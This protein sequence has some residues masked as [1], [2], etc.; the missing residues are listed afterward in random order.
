MVQTLFCSSLQNP[1]TR[2]ASTT[3]AINFSLNTLKCHLRNQKRSS[4][5]D[6]LFQKTEIFQKIGTPV[7]HLCSYS[8]FWKNGGKPDINSS[9]SLNEMNKRSKWWPNFSRW[10]RW[11]SK[12]YLECDIKGLILL[13]DIPLYLMK[14]SI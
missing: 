12:I 4:V 8:L 3:F 9:S 6:L 13:N 7:K 2:H 1:I 5:A 11:M 10:A 14:S